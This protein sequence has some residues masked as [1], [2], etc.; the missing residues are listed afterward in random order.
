MR[1]EFEAFIRW[2]RTGKGAQ[3]REALTERC[4]TN[5]EDYADLSVQRHWW[6]WQ[7]AAKAATSAAARRCVEILLSVNNYDNPMTAND[8][9]DAIE[10]EFG[11]KP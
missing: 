3:A 6:T 4:E 9:A 7:N 2:S 11:V 1:E 8:V 5:P 10:R